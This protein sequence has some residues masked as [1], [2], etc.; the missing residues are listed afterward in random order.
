MQ[1]AWYQWNFPGI[2]ELSDQ[3][4]QYLFMRAI[5]P[6]EEEEED[7]SK[8]TDD[9]ASITGKNKKHVTRRTVTTGRTGNTLAAKEVPRR[10]TTPTPIKKTLTTRAT[11]QNPG[12]P[13]QNLH[14]FFSLED[15]P[16][17]AQRAKR[18]TTRQPPLSHKQPSQDTDIPTQYSDDR[19][20]SPNLLESESDTDNNSVQDDENNNKED[21]LVPTQVHKAARDTNS[22]AESATQTT[23]NALR[24]EVTELRTIIADLQEWK[25][26][27]N[28][29][30]IHISEEATQAGDALR[31]TDIHELRD[32]LHT[33][34]ANVIQTETYDRHR[35][36]I[37]NETKQ[38]HQKLLRRLATLEAAQWVNRTE[39]K[40][41]NTTVQQYT[42]DSVTAL[43]HTIALQYDELHTKIKERSPTP[44]FINTLSAIDNKHEEVTE[45][46]DTLYTSIKDDLLTETKETILAEIDF[47]FRQDL[48]TQKYINKITDNVFADQHLE[49]A[50][51]SIMETHLADI[52]TYAKTKLE[53]H[54]ASI[55]EPSQRA[56]NPYNPVD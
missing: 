5:L 49:E 3:P 52:K 29:H 20:S 51:N 55:L 2:K 53:Q 43:T 34:K 40:K 1:R 44:G 11:R 16:S 27:K 17:W 50:M 19:T 12:T 9:Q 23:L 7:T 45:A 36:T 18:P 30:I 14:G 33:L 24:N 10:N 41:N 35:T 6:A 46:L 42:D 13:K 15:P 4:G 22:Q 37:A 39:Y 31:R 48:T 47:E 21:L 38:E 25:I 28:K 54:L 56:R 8:E 26:L 32:N